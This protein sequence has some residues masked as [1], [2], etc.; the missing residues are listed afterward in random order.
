MIARSN[1]R[2]INVGLISTI[3]RETDRQNGLS[4]RPLFRSFERKTSAQADGKVTAR[5]TSRR[6][7]RETGAVVWITG[8]L[9]RTITAQKLLK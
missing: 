2:Q 9:A 5:M 3:I 1:A 4:A 6:E 7:V 8:K